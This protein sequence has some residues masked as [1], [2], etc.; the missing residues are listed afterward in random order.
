MQAQLL[1]VLPWQMQHTSTLGGS[2]A[3]YIKENV[4]SHVW[5]WQNEL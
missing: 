5:I 1:S 3:K 2:I 4:C